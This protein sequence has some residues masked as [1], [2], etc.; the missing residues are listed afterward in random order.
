M[1]VAGVFCAI[2]NV[3][4]YGPEAEDPSAAANSDNVRVVDNTTGDVMSNVVNVPPM[5]DEDRY[6][7][8]WFSVN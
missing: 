7:N 8:T 5:T 2:C 1:T 4:K 6:C 3:N